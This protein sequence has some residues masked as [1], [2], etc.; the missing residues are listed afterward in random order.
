MTAIWDSWNAGGGHPYPNDKMVRF[1]LRNVPPERRPGMR[2]LDLGCGT[3]AHAVF[4]AE[5]GFSVVAA[6]ISAVAVHATRSRLEEAGLEADV[7]EASIDALTLP[8]QSIELVLCCGTLDSAGPDAAAGAL[9]LLSEAM[10]PGARG[11][12]LFAAA[13]D[14]R[15]LDENPYRLH[16]YREDEA[17]RLFEHRF[18]DVQVGS[19]FT[20]Y[21]DGTSEEREWLISATR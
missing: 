14:F 15:V 5:N 1:T 7:I 9:A 8:A 21:G 4:L 12:F 6:D 18:S 3:G 10:A 11:V 16:A 13:G 19:T 2:A 17:R 20:T